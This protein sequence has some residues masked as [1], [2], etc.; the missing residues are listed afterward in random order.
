VLFGLVVLVVGLM[1]YVDANGGRKASA[2]FNEVIDAIMSLLGGGVDFSTGSNTVGG[3]LATVGFA[4][5]ILV[6]VSTYTAIVINIMT[7]NGVKNDVS[8]IEDAIDQNMKICV[9]EALSSEL[10][11]K[12]PEAADLLIR[13][14]SDDLVLQNMDEGKCRVCA[15]GDISF[16]TQSRRCGK[17][18]VQMLRSIARYTNDW[19]SYK[20]HNY[21][22]LALHC[23]HFHRSLTPSCGLLLDHSHLSSAMP[24]ATRYQHMVNWLMAQAKTEGH[25][26][27]EAK[28]AIEKYAKV[29][30]CPPVAPMDESKSF[31]LK[32]M[33]GTIMLTLIVVSIGIALR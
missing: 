12:Y 8:T 5:F 27:R 1:R 33:S 17:Q 25:Y 20:L 24:V 4:F 19:H 22:P 26:E 31:G 9:M 16:L 7:Y 32:E 21:T 15:M 13:S 23:C 11:G 6:S 3:R 28:V 2:I 29:E 14:S 30:P 18:P 10:I